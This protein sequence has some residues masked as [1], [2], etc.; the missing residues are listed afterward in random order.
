MAA[1]AESLRFFAIA[2][3][4]VD[5]A[6]PLAPAFSGI[7]RYAAA[8]Q[9]LFAA[10]FFFLWLDPGRYSAYR[11]LL[12]IGK[13]ASAVCFVPL[14]ASLLRD[15]RGLALGLAFLVA[16]AD[17]VSLCV[18]ALARGGMEGPSAVPAGQGPSEPSRPGQGPEEIE[19]VEGL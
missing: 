6:G 3:L 1:I 18:L 2:F 17:I 14:A 11:P 13:A 8:P 7:L 19:R 5:V 9:L 12:L 10:G 4:A 15:P 16:A